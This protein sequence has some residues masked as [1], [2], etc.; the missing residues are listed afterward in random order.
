MVSVKS[1]VRYISFGFALDPP[2]QL[3]LICAYHVT[4]NASL[5]TYTY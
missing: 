4:A 3:Q 2:Q 1:Q 5:G